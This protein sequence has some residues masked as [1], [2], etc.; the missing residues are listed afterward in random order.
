MAKPRKTALASDAKSVA[1]AAVAAATKPANLTLVSCVVRVARN[2]RVSA[3]SKGF[4]TS[5]QEQ[6]ISSAQLVAASSGASVSSLEQH[7]VLEET[8]SLL[9]RLCV[10]RNSADQTFSPVD[11]N[12]RALVWSA[13]EKESS[14]LS[15][16]TAP[17]SWA[18]PEVLSWSRSNGASAAVV[19]FLQ[20][21]AI[22]ANSLLALQEDDLLH[23]EEFDLS[24]DSVQQVSI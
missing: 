8:K 15:S 24:S 5:E 12:F 11:L 9:A 6:N 4:A 17:S 2:L 22:D 10:E 19:N 16:E 13:S 1:A 21:A 18:N 7:Q 23:A 20:L 3:C 14:M